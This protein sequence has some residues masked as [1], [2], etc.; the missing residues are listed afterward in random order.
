MQVNKEVELVTPRDKNI[1]LNQIKLMQVKGESLAD[2]ALN[3]SLIA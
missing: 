1:N 2:L 3:A